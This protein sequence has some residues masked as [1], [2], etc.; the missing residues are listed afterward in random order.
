MFTRFNDNTVETK[1]IK[2]LVANTQVPFIS[3]WKPNDFAIRGMMY[4]TRDAIWRCNHTGYPESLTDTC[5]PQEHT[6]I[7]NRDDKRVYTGRDEIPYFTKIAPYVF[8]DEYFNVTGSYQSN[9]LGYDATT[10]FYLGQYLRMMRDIFDL[11]L[12]PFYNCFCGDYVSGIDF[13]SSSRIYSS[14]TEQFKIASVPV[15]FGKTYTIAL[16]SDVPVETMLV[17][18]GPKGLITDLTNNLNDIIETEIKDDVYRFDA[19]GTYQKFLKTSFEHPIQYRTKDWHQ[20]Y[21]VYERKNGK[22]QSVIDDELIMNNQNYDQ[23]LGQFEKYLRLLI[24]VPVSNSSSLVVLEGD[25]SLDQFYES[26][27]T[28]Y[29]TW[30]NESSYGA[31]VNNRLVTGEWVRPTVVTSHF[32]QSEALDNDGKVIYSDFKQTDTKVDDRPVLLSPLGLL[33]MS[34]GNS[35]AFSNRLIEYLLQHV[36]NPLEQFGQNIERIQTYVKSYEN[37][38]RNNTPRYSGAVTTGVWDEGLRKY[39]FDLV[40]SSQYLT[41][42][43][44]VNGYVDKDTESIV[45]RG[46]RV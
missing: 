37:T 8:G 15:K 40:Q 34:D 30:T 33:Q 9:I 23:A 17:V 35:Y 46:Q 31:T 44:D 32:T 10:H 26:A 29:V 11:N 3:T 39:I 2:N 20:L 42:K 5:T 24:K 38:L 36:I 27:N 41:T 43:V 6:Q 7:L 45:T 16:S 1:F 13:D 18:Y 25:Y 21:N 22:L 12:M 4:I 14:S 19:K 28:N